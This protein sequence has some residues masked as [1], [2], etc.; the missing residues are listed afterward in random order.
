MKET[1]W[2]LTSAIHVICMSH[3][4]LKQLFI[5]DWMTF[6][7]FLTEPDEHLMSLE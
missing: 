5:K 7:R 2:V 1:G 4:I 6:V 3:D